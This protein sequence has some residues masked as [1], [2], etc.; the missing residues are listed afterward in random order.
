MKP[1]QK[2]AE[3]LSVINRLLEEAY[4]RPACPLSHGNPLQ[5]LVAVMLSAQCTDA[6]VNQLTPA[7]F[8]RFPT[9]KDFAEAAPEELEKMIRPSGFFKVKAARIID[10]CRAMLERHGGRVPDTME[11]LAALPGIGR[12]SANVVLGNAFGKPGL[13]VD[14]HV[15]RLAN[16]IGLV[17]DTRDPV[18]IEALIT[19]DLPPE[20][21]TNFSH[22]LIFHGRKR[23]P[24][25]KPDC[26]NCEIRIYCET[27]KKVVQA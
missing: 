20:L 1:S 4:G 16:R 3:R 10:C 11:E 15:M 6:R 8:K 27:G 21:W 25:R 2:A 18:K 7:L 23:C 13:P 14:T 17:R 5:L 19:K 22:L 9:V 24:A 26:Q 12:K